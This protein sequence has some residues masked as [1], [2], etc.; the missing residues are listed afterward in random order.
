MLMQLQQFEKRLFA[1]NRKVSE[2][3]R[4]VPL[5]ANFALLLDLEIIPM[6]SGVALIT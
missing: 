5:K 6:S 3:L 2:A 1:S 4:C